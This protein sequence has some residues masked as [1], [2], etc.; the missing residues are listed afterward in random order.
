[1]VAVVGKTSIKI[2]ELV[3]NNIIDGEIVSGRLILRTRG[4]AEIDAGALPTAGSQSIVSGSI[5]G[6]HLILH[7]LDGDDIDA[8]EV[9]PSVP[10]PLD[11]MPIGFVYTSVV[12]TSPQTMFGGTWVR[13]GQGRVLVGQDS[14]Q[15]EFDTVEEVGGEKT[16]ALS[17][18]EIPSHTHS[19]SHDHASFNS[20]SSVDH[21][22]AV[23]H[24]HPSSSTAAA[25]DHAHAIDHNHAVVVTGTGGSHQHATTRKTGTGSSTGEARGSATADADGVT[26]SVPGHTHSANV[27]AYTGASGSGGGHSH[28][29][30]VPAYAGASGA[31]GAHNH[32]VDV[33]A[34]T[35]TSG[36]SGGGAAH[37][38]LQ[39]YMVVY[40][41]KRTA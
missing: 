37:N 8:G 7:T 28:V 12:S 16:H 34:Y 36:A 39:P 41:W 2:D 15:S 9:V 40:M 4:G 17:T 29:N 3:N 1:M 11:F 20:S 24:D 10:T 27:P 30:D 6:T 13:I 38:N 19:V 31:G 14:A 22:H 21:T 18:F 23:D 5:V 26:Q 25:A 35:G 32:S 33:P